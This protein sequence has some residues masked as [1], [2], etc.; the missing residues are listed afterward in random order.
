MLY[1]SQF[2]DE[3]DITLKKVQEKV[4]VNLKKEVSISTIASYLEGKSFAV[5]E[6]Y[7]EPFTLNSIEYKGK[8]AEYV[9][10][11]NRFIQENK[12]IV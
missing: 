2:E 8:S 9:R 12:Q 7:H 1:I 6:V 5:K 3:C 11:L 4:R 10:Q